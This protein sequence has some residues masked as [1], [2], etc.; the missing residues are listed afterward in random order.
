MVVAIKVDDFIIFVVLFVIVMVV[1]I[2]IIFFIVVRVFDIV[3]INVVSCV[4]LSF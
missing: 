2:I 1:I 3:N 4:V